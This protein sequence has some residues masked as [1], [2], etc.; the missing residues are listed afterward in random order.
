MFQVDIHKIVQQF[1][2]DPDA[3][4]IFSSG[5]FLFLF[6]AFIIVYYFLSP[7]N[8]PKIIFVTLFSLYFYYKSS[9]LYFVLLLSATVVDYTLA[10]L[11]FLT[12]DKLKRKLMLIASLSINLGV[13]A[14]F[15]YTNFL[16]DTAY[17]LTGGSYEPM[18]IFLPVGISFFTFQSLSYTIDVYRGN[19]KP[20]NNILD[21]AFYLSFFPQLV[22]GP[23]VRA[24]DFLPQIHKPTFVSK[25]MLGRGVFL[26]FTGLFKKAVISDYISINFVDRVF[27][28]PL[29]YTGFE[30]LVA[31]YGYALQI[32][33]DFSGYSDMAIGIAL[34][35]GFHF[36][37]NFNSP[38]QSLNISEFWRRWH[39]SLSSWLRDYLYISLGGN[40]KGK[41]RTYINLMITMLLGGLWHGASWKFVIWGGLHGLALAV[42]KAIAPFT[43]VAFRGK[44][45]DIFSVLLTFHFVCFCWLFFR[46]PSIHAVGE[47]LNQ[48]FSN[49]QGSV[50][51]EFI[52]GYT[53]VC[54]LLLLGYVLHFVPN[55]IQDETERAVKRMPLIFKALCIVLVIVL[56]IQT[57]SADV[58]PF[59]YFQF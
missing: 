7:T 26:I 1:F 23:I 39:I 35:L 32:Y 29:L 28:A 34:L 51:T 59:I 9:G 55:K 44:V 54:I 21:Y 38:Y 49:F 33:C 46:A 25:E 41:V 40:R 30:N 43:S 37:I 4:L 3:P 19:L 24:A 57:K 14:Y 5:L 42:H 12:K 18:D 47:M 11:I 20:V 53:W 2:Y 56:V 15:K 36:N 50:F 10:G 27:D 22:A 45:W 48:V 58:Q 13:L 31:M 6:T 8:R 52:S 16:F 17:G